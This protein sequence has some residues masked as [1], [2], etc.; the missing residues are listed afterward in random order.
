MPKKVAIIG[1]G[2]SGLVM[3]KTLLHHYPP[4]HFAP[5][6]F[7]SRQT[8]GGLWAVTGPN[9]KQTS[10]IDAEMRTNLSRFTV[11]FS[12][13]SWELNV[14][15]VGV[16]DTFP[17]AAQVNEYLDKYAARYIP[18]HVLRLGCRVLNTRRNSDGWIVK[19]E[20]DKDVQ[21]EEETFDYLVVAS[22]YFSSPHIP[23]IRGLDSFSP[24][25]V[26]HSSSLASA[27]GRLFTELSNL[28][29]KLLVVGGSM[30]GAE[31][32]SS[33][34][35]ASSSSSNNIQIHHLATR[36]FWAVPTYLPDASSG[37]FLPL[38]IV[39][40]DLARRP[41]GDIQY[42]LNPTA[43]PERAL[44]VNKYFSTILG[45]D[46]SD[47]ARF[48]HDGAAA[49]ADDL[50][51]RPPWVAVTDH[52]AE[53]V[54]AGDITTSLGRVE[55]VN[56]PAGSDRGT[57]QVRESSSS[58]STTTI[59]DVAGI[60]LATGFT[61]FNALAF[62]PD[63]VLAA[64]EY[65]PDDPV[66]PLVLDEKATF[67]PAV[68]DLGFVG[69][70]RGPY[71]GVMEMQAR[72]LAQQWDRQ[73]TNATALQMRNPRLSL[74][75]S[76]SSA[77]RRTQFPM[78]DYVGLMETFARELGIQRTSLLF[79]TETPPPPPGG[80][81]ERTGPAVPVR[82]S[83]QSTTNNK[84]NNAEIAATHSALSDLLR[85]AGERW[86]HRQ[87]ALSQAVFRA[88]HGSWRVEQKLGEE[89][90]EA[91]LFSGS[92]TFRPRAV[93]SLSLSSSSSSSSAGIEYL[94]HEEINKNSCDAVFSISENFIHIN[95]P[96]TTLSRHIEF[97][98]IHP[99][100]DQDQDGEQYQYRH[101]ARG[102]FS[103]NPSKKTCE[104]VF[105]IKGVQIV[106]WQETIISSPSEEKQ[107]KT[108]TRFPSYK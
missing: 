21:K 85:P 29:G 81:N 91:L 64:L 102:I 86:P 100:Q 103:D 78:G 94:Y 90:E 55:A 89:E 66:F 24:E 48:S 75:S 31:A 1:A 62:L 9:E 51:Q 95:Q 54:R 27:K 19:W 8:V 18:G 57:V 46:Q 2:P 88:L 36:P 22:G 93:S 73:D 40:Y 63:D 59:K 76:S 3:A 17:R 5:V 16:D 20:N 80:K 83:V 12:D 68:P 106:S 108:Y 104:Y 14:G 69:M 96:D 98:A 50:D 43:P 23:S 26:I 97:V 61:P 37:S 52:Y 11:C 15:G 82:Y 42:S 56:W 92:A 45:S 72:S 105:H 7:E 60:V 70:Y 87:H 35:L 6:I 28:P 47:V 4:G 25:R 99:D 79:G 30:S 84:N 107:I 34:A 71:W 77:S 44:L 33:L 101:S 13:F 74:S 38:D 10:F 65:A 58:S 67:H 32:A 39:M 41:H 49:A 53:F